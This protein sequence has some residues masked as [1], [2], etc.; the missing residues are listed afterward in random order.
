[1]RERVAYLGG[2]VR[3]AGEEGKGTTIVITI[4]KTPGNIQAGEP[5]V[6]TDDWQNSR[7]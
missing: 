7:A 4:P 1:M 3:L 6:E 2:N 5:A